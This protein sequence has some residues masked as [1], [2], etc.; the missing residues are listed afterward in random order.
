MVF[1]YAIIIM[2]AL[3]LWA[4]LPPPEKPAPRTPDELRNDRVDRGFFN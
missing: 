4:Y 1:I 3:L 2:A